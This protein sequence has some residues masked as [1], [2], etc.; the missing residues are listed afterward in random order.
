MS[1]TPNNLPRPERDEQYSYDATLAVSTP[2]TSA[3]GGQA[4]ILEA[5]AQPHTANDENDA[6]P[7]YM[8]GGHG[9]KN[10][11]Y[12]RYIAEQYGRNA[13]TVV[14]EEPRARDTHYWVGGSNTTDD[15]GE[16]VQRTAV[17]GLAPEWAGAIVAE[18]QIALAQDIL[19]AA[20]KLRADRIDAIGQS[21][22]SLRVVIAAD[23]APDVVR[24]VILAYRVESLQRDFH[25][26][27]TGVRKY[28]RAWRQ[29]RT[30]IDP[31][32]TFDRQQLQLPAD[33]TAFEHKQPRD[34]QS[35]GENVLLSHHAPLLHNIRRRKQSVGIGQ[36]AG[37]HD[38]IA[39]PEQA[40]ADL[41]SQG[42]VD[43]FCVLPGQHA[44]GNHAGRLDS[45]LQLLG[46]VEQ[47]R[48]PGASQALPLRQ[49][50]VDDAGLPAARLAALQQ[51]MDQLPR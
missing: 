30:N 3:A 41:C 21:M 39:P 4:R 43:Y 18:K 23:Q 35:N 28:A 24:N 38:Y 47:A 7:I 33:I 5:R 12:L 34:V 1:F 31:T 13:F 46:L 20:E 51:Q 45:A 14:Y 37:E 48:K 25:Q 8:H 32:A 49:R 36:V 42:D 50:F 40:I 16:R 44:I 15:R 26:A 9:S 10:A 11:V 17:R 27:L 29:N 6:V 22:A 2:F 19:T